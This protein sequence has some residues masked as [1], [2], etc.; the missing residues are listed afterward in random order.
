M[1]TNYEESEYDPILDNIDENEMFTI[2]NSNLQINLKTLFET[3]TSKQ[4]LKVKKNE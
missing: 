4:F 1:D 2:E 3:K